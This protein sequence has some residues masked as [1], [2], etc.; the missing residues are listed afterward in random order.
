LE[1]ALGLAITELHR[2]H[3]I[4]I[5][6]IV[7]LFTAGPARVLNLRDRGSLAVGNCGDVTI[8]DPKQRWTFDA[9]NSLSLSRNTPFHGWQLTGKVAATIV[10]GRIVYRGQ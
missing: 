8:F 3:K 7:E 5:R 2:A 9:E 4:P 1:T 6:R 10:N